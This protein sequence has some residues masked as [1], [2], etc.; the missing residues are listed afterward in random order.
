MVERVVYCPGTILGPRDLYVGR[1]RNRV[2]LHSAEIGEWGW[3]G[4]PFDSVIFGLDRCIEMYAKAFISKMQA[5][6]EFAAR[7]QSLDVD[8]VFCWCR[9]DKN[10]HGDFIVAYLEER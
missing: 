9:L 7:I 4:N 8:R 3:L 1:G 5:D 6:P 2:N 10:C